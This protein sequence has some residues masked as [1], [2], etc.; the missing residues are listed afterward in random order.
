MGW[1]LLL[2]GIV[3]VPIGFW[4]EY[5][6]DVAPITNV[7]GL[8]IGF[9]LFI[10]VQDIKWWWEDRHHRRILRERTSHLRYRE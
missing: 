1:K 9:G 8:L 7:A 10:T 2:A 3:L 6:R 5:P 4:L